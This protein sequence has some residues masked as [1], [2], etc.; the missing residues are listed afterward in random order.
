VGDFDKVNPHAA[1]MKLLTRL[2]KSL[3][4]MFSIP[5]ENVRGHREFNSHKTCPGRLFNLDAFRAQL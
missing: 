2:V 5:V 3:M 1:Q 4:E